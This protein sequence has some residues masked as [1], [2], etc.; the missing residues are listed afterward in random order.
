MR[1]K[2]IILRSIQARRA[3]ARDGES[4]RPR[5]RSTGAGLPILLRLGWT[6][7]A[8]GVPF[9]R[10]DIWP[11]RSP[12][13]P[14]RGQQQPAAAGEPAPDCRIGA[15]SMSK[16]AL[17]CRGLSPSHQSPTAGRLDGP[18]PAVLRRAVRCPAVP[19]RDRLPLARP[20]AATTRWPRRARFS[21]RAP[22]SS[23]ATTTASGAPTSKWPWRWATPSAG[24]WS[25]GARG[26][27]LSHRLEEESLGGGLR[28]GV[29]LRLRGNPGNGPP[30]D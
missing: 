21:T 29:D 25:T 18:H 19:R 9:V 14:P 22:G 20:V 8:A 1:A 6:L 28:E 17:M 26:P 11:R 27:S 24:C 7:R 10:R 30:A 15:T 23:G 12:D 4:T 2:Q 13:S 3:T 16:T 5:S